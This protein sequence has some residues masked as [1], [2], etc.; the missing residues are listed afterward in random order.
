MKE[1]TELLEFMTRPSQRL[2][3]DIK[4]I[5]GDILILGAGGKVGPSLAVTAARACKAAGVSK[6]VLAATLLDRSGTAEAMSAWGVE[7]LEADLSDPVQLAA[8][9]DCPNIIFMAG[10]KFGTSDNQSLTWAANVLLPAK[11]CERFPDARFVVFSTGNIYGDV[12]ALSGGSSED[13]E[14]NPDGEYGQTCLGRERVFEYYAGKN[15]T[16][17]LLFR[18]NYAIEPRYGVLFDIASAV[19]EGRPVSLGRGVYNCIWQGDV[20]EYTLRS[21]LHTA[22]PPA[23]LNVTG[24]QCVST[25]WTAETFGKIFGKEPVYTG[26]ERPVGIYSNTTK[27]GGLL[28]MPLVA[29]DDMIRM[30]ADWIAS[31]GESISAPTHFEQVDGKY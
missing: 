25:R 18:L 10:R 21:L 4:K 8:L 14:P 2:V 6:R 26:E 17:S 13:N 20:C 1:S 24:P 23:A 19:Y 16:K 27:L 12:S 28:G 7:V 9:P 29:L 31:G 5:E 30:Q 3:E 22:N 11:V 15:G